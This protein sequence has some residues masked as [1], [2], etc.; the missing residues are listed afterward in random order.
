MRG[1]AAEVKAAS[2]LCAGGKDTGDAA[3]LSE[4]VAV[5]SNGFFA[6]LPAGAGGGCGGGGAPPSGG[7]RS[8]LS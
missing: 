3:E 1:L 5:R 7:S 2:S 4:K 8:A 6:R